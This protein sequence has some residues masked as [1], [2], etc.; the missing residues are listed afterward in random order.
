VVFDGIV[1]NFEKMEV[2]R[3]GTS[4][5]LTAREFKTL[6]FFIQNADRVIT[7]TE[8]LNKVCGN[9]DG[10]TACRIIDNHI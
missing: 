1:V 3:N 5:P 7:R 4:I 10:N 9:E 8:L 6:Q 2:T